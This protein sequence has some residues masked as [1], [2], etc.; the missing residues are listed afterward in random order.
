MKEEEKELTP[1]NKKEN[2]LVFDLEEMHRLNK[3]NNLPLDVDKAI[4][5]LD[6]I[7]GLSHKVDSVRNTEKA[8]KANTQIYSIAKIGNIKPKMKM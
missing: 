1:L 7:N 2:S 8:N 4:L 5:L 3:E 6:R